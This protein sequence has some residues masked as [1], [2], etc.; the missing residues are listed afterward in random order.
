MTFMIIMLTSKERA[1]VGRRTL[2]VRVRTWG[3]FFV[4]LLSYLRKV[5]FEETKN[6][7]KSFL[8]KSFLSKKYIH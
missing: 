3:P 1:D 7:S 6:V 5:E 2:A 4:R 8:K